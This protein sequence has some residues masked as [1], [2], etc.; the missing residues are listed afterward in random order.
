M[1]SVSSNITHSLMSCISICRKRG[2]HEVK[3][4]EKMK[5]QKMGELFTEA[6]LSSQWN[7]LAVTQA[8][9]QLESVCFG[10]GDSKLGK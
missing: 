7:N 8:T 4:R 6:F 10:V 5:T 1:L 2:D 3:V 9:D